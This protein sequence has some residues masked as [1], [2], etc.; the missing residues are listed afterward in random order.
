MEKKDKKK[1]SGFFDFLKNSNVKKLEKMGK[2]R[3]GKDQS[4]E[5]K[6]A[7]R[8]KDGGVVKKK[9][10]YGAGEESIREDSIKSRMKITER[11]ETA[12]EKMVR[13]ANEANEKYRKEKA[14][15]KKGKG[16]FSKIMNMFKK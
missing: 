3:H 8:Y 15:K 11:E 14:D 10:K 13:E 16:G 9:G 2:D 12:T 5:K 7:S 1:K 6:F 4:D